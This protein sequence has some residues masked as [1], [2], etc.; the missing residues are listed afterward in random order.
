MQLPCVVTSAGDAAEI[1]GDNGFIVPV[2]DS[3]ALADALLRMRYLDP[4]I[5]KNL[6]VRGAEKVRTEYG[7]EKICRKYEE[8]FSLI[9]KKVI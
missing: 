4:R 9:L 6:G 5:R 7:I 2:K 8:I 3:M 1:L